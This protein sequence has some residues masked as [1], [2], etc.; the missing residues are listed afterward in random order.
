MTPADLWIEAGRL[1]IVLAGFALLASVI[2]VIETRIRATLRA[3]TMSCFEEFAANMGPMRTTQ[4]RDAALSAIAA[5]LAANKITRNQ[6]KRQR[7]LVDV[8]FEAYA[9][10][11]AKSRF[12]GGKGAA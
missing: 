1:G 6:A 3:K 12:M 4:D 7:H 9:L 2:W 11:A 8:A 5:N 10:P